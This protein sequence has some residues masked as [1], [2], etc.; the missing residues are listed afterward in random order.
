MDTNMLELVRVFASLFVQRWDQYAVQQRD[1]SYW[2]V[3]EPL[4]WEH[5]AA[6]LAG[7]WTLGTYLLDDA[8]RCSF[9]VFDADQLDGLERL[10]LL[11]EVLAEQG[12][13][14]VLEA[15]RRGGHLWLH[16]MEALPASL[17]RTWL[18]PYAHDFG[19]ELYPKQDMLAAG[20]AGSLIR[21]PLGVHQKSRGW[22]PFVQLTD[23]WELVPVGETVWDCCA[24]LSQAVERVSVP[25]SMLLA[26]ARASDSGT[27]PVALAQADGE[28]ASAFAS[29][30]AWCLAQ[31]IGTVIGRYVALDRRGVGS[32]PFKEHHAHGDR[33]PSFQVFAGPDPHWYCYTWQRAGDL[34][35]FLR[36]YH[37]LSV[38][39]AWRRL[40]AGMLL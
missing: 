25:A 17:V 22:Y 40:H 11:W 28:T 21:L 19:M 34:F 37:G 35:D 32:C 1:G 3:C 20:G 23:T 6:H 29:I 5:L 18:S 12:I 33:R 4:T 38:Q 36:L 16:L 2:R 13:P 27:K 7:R 14:A 31:D 30:R 24:W 15:S 39:E 10:A 8:S 9:A 26:S